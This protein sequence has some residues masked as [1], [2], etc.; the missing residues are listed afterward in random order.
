MQGLGI[1]GGGTS[2]RLG[3]SFQGP[4]VVRCTH[5]LSFRLIHS[6]SQRFT[7]D[8]GPPVRAGQERSRTVVNGVAQSSK[9]CE[10]SN[11]DRSYQREPWAP[12]L[13]DWAMQRKSWEPVDRGQLAG[14]GETLGKNH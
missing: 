3:G 8:R 5:R 1:L 11:T 12:R 10:R 2:R 9:A 7:G 14:L 4:W 13:G 6:C